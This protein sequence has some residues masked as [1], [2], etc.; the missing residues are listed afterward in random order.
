M[1]MLDDPL[2]RA[3]VGLMAIIIPSAAMILLLVKFITREKKPER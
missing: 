1:N 2:I 3:M